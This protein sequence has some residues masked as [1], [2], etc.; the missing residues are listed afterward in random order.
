[1]TSYR[2]FANPPGNDTWAQIGPDVVEARS[3]REAI[4]RALGNRAD[5]SSYTSYVA[6]PTRSWKPVTVSVETKTS[7]KFS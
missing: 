4:Q 2:V 7:L 6:V 3:A 1:M 5:A